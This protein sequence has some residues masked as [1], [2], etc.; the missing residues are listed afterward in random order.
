MKTLIPQSAAALCCALATSISAA[1]ETLELT[2]MTV[3][4][5]V[6][7]PAY[8]PLY[9][10][11]MSTGRETAD[12]LRDLPG[13]SGSRMGGHG[14]DV[15]IRGLSANRINVLLDGAYVFGACPNRMDPP[16]SYAA[17]GSYEEITVIRGTQT[18]AYGGGGPGGT[19]LFERNTPAFAAGE[20]VRGEVSAGYRE[21]GETAEAAADLAAGT[22]LFFVRGLASIVDARNYDDG[23]GNEVRSAYTGKQGTFITGYTPDAD[24]RLEFSYDAQRNEDILFPG[25]GMDSPQADND[26]LRLKFESGNRSGVVSDIRVDLYDSSVTHVMDNY[27]LRTRPVMSPELRAPSTSDTHG[28][29]L[30]VDIDS[31]VGRW[32]LGIDGQYNEREADRFND[33]LGVLQSVLWPGVSIDQTGAFAELS[34]PLTTQTRIV[35]GLRY[36]YVVSQASRADAQPAGM[37][38]TPNELY[39]L[40]YDGARAEKRTDHQI[41]G[42]LRL[43]HDLSSQDA[44]VYL[45]LSRSVRAADATERYLSS[46]AMMPSMRWVGNP[47]IAPEVYHQAEAGLHYKRGLWVFD[48]SLFYSDVS[49]YILRDRFTAANNN[50]TIYRNVD[51]TLTGGEVTIARR[52][53]AWQSELGA[54]YVQAQNDTDDRPIAQTPPLEGRASLEYLQESWLAGVRVRAAA[55]QTRVDTTS[56]TGIEGQG[57][58]VGQTAG[59]AVLDLFA[60]IDLN[61]VLTL[62]AGVDNLFDRNY[63]QHLNRANAFDPTQVQVNEPGRSAWLKLNGAF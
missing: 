11:E 53:G 58:D 10:E 30:V 35:S 49:D 3:E 59:W 2:P 50:A 46:N 38:L 48:G 32:T 12:V 28:G 5:A 19:I 24:T 23:E 40:Y 51:A 56:S 63:A 7:S 45:G 9:V 43:E 44:R 31:S 16:T 22:P 13:V 29:R 54:A 1:Q 26:T 42:L 36:D 41:G 25:A 57:L 34:H 39:A 52:F 8:T 17:P 27:T 4:E 18:L 37:S 47:N 20:S 33:T 62:Q 60:S 14:T 61:S 55:Q 6:M 21:N 15:S